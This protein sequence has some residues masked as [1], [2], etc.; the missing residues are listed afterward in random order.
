MERVLI[1]YSLDV[2]RIFWQNSSKAVGWMYIGLQL[3]R[4][5]FKGFAKYYTSGRTLS[6]GFL[7]RSATSAH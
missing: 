4:L 5:P 3:A 7:I 6:Y 1:Y 2:I